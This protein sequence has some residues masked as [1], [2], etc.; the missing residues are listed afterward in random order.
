VIVPTQDP[1]S[2]QGVPAA[3]AAD[4]GLH[5]QRNLFA[6]KEVEGP[7]PVLVPALNHDFDRFTDSVPAAVFELLAQEP[8]GQC[9]VR[10][11]NPTARILLLMQ[12]SVSP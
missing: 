3:C 1:E 8:P 7:S 6:M 10:F 12:G 5:I 2:A 4:S 11:L 9:V